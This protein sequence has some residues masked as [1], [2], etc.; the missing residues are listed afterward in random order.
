MNNRNSLRQPSS[1]VNMLAGALGGSAGV[2]VTFPFDVAQTRLQQSSVLKLKSAT[3]MLNSAV[4]GS[5]G[6]GGGWWW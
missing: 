5:G 3:P 6:G 2:L 4:V 1:T